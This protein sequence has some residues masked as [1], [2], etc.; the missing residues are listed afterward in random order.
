MSKFRDKA[1]HGRAV[2]A[3]KRKFKVWPSAYASGFVV[4]EYKRLYK[5]KH[6]SMRGA[7]RGD[8][9]GK[10]FAEE[11]VRI[12]ASGKIAGPCGG[13]SSKE[14]KPKCLPK[15]KA[16]ALTTAERKRLVARKRAKDPKPNR[17]GKAIMTS[18]KPSKDAEVL[19]KMLKKK[20]EQTTNI[21]DRL[22]KL[23]D[24]YKRK[25]TH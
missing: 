9:L 1:L 19:A 7:F 21:R 2:A 10:W 16:Q 3:A 4:Q 5:K 20:P 12:T 17:R 15:A 22:S 11:W 25:N 6:G 8:D 13:R 24:S 23:M 14:G 18:S